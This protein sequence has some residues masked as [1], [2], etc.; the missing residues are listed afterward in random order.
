MDSEIN[1][2]LTLL[3]KAYPEA[4]YYLNFSNPLELLIA[5]ILS[6]QCTDVIVNST[7]EKLFKKYKNA[8]NYAKADLSEFE[9]EIKSITF[10]RNK[11]KNIIKT[12]EILQEKFNGK[13]PSSMND[14]IELP[15]IS[16]KTANV[17]QQNAFNIVEGIVVDT[18]VIKLTN[19]LGWVDTVNPAKI[20]NQLMQ[21]FPKENWKMIPH[22]LKNHGRAVCKAPIPVCSKCLLIKLCP[23]IGVEKFN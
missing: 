19:R 20:E 17:I 22:L 4:K 3:E 7:T 8:K 5:A 16:R 1:E 9:N 21:M 6:A 14:L 18:W 11:T 12:C 2:E 13:V 10:F 23:K 15:G